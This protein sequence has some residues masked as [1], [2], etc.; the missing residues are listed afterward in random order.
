M[1]TD[2]KTM[3]AQKGFATSDDAERVVLGSI[4]LDDSSFER[5]ATQLESADFATDIHALIYKRMVEIRAREERID[6][7]TIAHELLRHNE[8]E[9]VGGL[10]YL[11][12]LDQGLPKLSNIESYT[13][14][15]REQSALRRIA[16]I[17]NATAF[18][19]IKAEDAA[20]VIIAEAQYEIA[21]LSTAS[22]V[23]TRAVNLRGAIER[24]GG[25]KQFLEGQANVLRMP[26]GFPLLDDKM[27]GFET[28]KT[29]VIA[30]DTSHGKTAYALNLAT[31]LAMSGYPGLYFTLEM[32][33]D[34]M[35]QRM[36]CSQAEVSTSKL[37]RGHFDHDER[38]AV[39]AT[40]DDL[41]DLPLY[42]D[43]TADLTAPGLI[44]QAR[45]AKQKYGIKFIVVDYMQILNYSHNPVKNGRP[46]TEYEGLTAFSRAFK[47]MAKT[48][49]VA[50]IILSQLSKDKDR[51]TGKIRRPVPSDLHGTGAISKDADVVMFVW[52]PWLHARDRLELRD[53]AELIIAKNRAGEPGFINYEFKGR[54]TRFYECADQL[55]KEIN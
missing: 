6:H 3:L 24:A 54:Y 29:Y 47:M 27:L 21:Q 38:L 35:L 9:K 10:T 12:S 53:H 20:E 19:A 51:S 45:R 18:R 4:I 16:L 42:F 15:V 25:L 2:V 22:V 1:P 52:R 50:V 11:V 41:A 43:D 13:R 23:S 37:L 39:A 49:D 40:A 7:V 48:L 17:S 36:I 33:R 14:I 31:N 26:T 30:G 55:Q 8:L 32:S 28:G 46:Q 5:V 44:M 34:E